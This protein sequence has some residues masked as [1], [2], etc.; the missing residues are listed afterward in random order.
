MAHLSMARMDHRFLCLSLASVAE[1]A[2]KTREPKAISGHRR[3]TRATNIMLIISFSNRAV[4]IRAIAA[5]IID[6]MASLYV[7]LFLE[8]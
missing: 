6:T 4:D 2:W 8:N 3:S 7:L 1:E 5:I